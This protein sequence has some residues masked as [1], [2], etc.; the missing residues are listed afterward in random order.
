VGEEVSVALTEVY[1]TVQTLE[2]IAPLEA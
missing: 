1:R 2:E